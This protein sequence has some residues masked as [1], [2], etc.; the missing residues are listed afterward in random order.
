MHG[1]SRPLVGIPTPRNG[2][3]RSGRTARL[4]G[5]GHAGRRNVRTGETLTSERAGGHTVKED[6]LPTAPLVGR[7]DEMAVLRAA[8]D[9]LA[10]G[11]RGLVVVRGE[12]GIGKTRLL[13]ALRELSSR[14][15]ST[16][17]HGHAT[18]LESDAPFAPVLEALRHRETASGSTG[19]THFGAQRRRTLRR[20]GGGF[21]VRWS[22][23]WMSWPTR[24]PS[25]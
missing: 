17:Y 2:R 5:V 24:I 13:D 20:P 12:A 8:V 21:I 14:R 16:T 25:S 7:D 22:T 3:L 18:E 1:P 6:R 19:L 4:T 9:A 11:E 23:C 15:G 10:R